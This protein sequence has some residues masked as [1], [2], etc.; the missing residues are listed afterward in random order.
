MLG[1]ALLMCSRFGRAVVRWR[2]ACASCVRRLIRQ[3]RPTAATVR[4]LPNPSASPR[5]RLLI[6]SLL[7]PAY[8]TFVAKPTPPPVP[9]FLESISQAIHLSAPALPLRAQVP[10]IRPRTT[11]E[12]KRYLL[13]GRRRAVRI[14][15][16][17]VR[18]ALLLAFR[19]QLLAIDRATR[20]GLAPG[21]ESESDKEALML[22][23]QREL[24]VEAFM[25]EDPAI[26]VDGEWVVASIEGFMDPVRVPLAEVKKASQQRGKGGYRRLAVTRVES[27]D[28]GPANGRSLGVLRGAEISSSP[29][30][31]SETMV[32]SLWIVRPQHCKLYLFRPHTSNATLTSMRAGNSKQILF[33]GTLMRWLE[34]VS[35][36]AARRVSVTPWS[37][38]AIDSLSFNSAVHPGEVVYIRAV[39]T[40]V[41]DSSVECY[42][43]AMAED[44]N[45][46]EP[47]MRLVSESFFSLVRRR[48]PAQ[49]A[50]ENT[51][52][53]RARQV[54]I[55]PVSGR[56]LKGRLRQV[57][58]PDGPAMRVAEGADKRR[59]DRLQD[60]RILQRY[61]SLMLDGLSLT[62]EL[63]CAEFMLEDSSSW[64]AASLLSGGLTL[65]PLFLLLRLAESAGLLTRLPNTIVHRF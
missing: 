40:K 25:K 18:D 57:R 26:S 58:V 55:D 19:A 3:F 30:D 24:V 62:L 15:G 43:L 41:W 49:Q 4:H 35:S 61:V 48:F 36:V 33:G 60:K 28:D 56:P 31:L 1:H 34:E 22:E 46:R 54:A 9:T 39:V 27:D 16:R 44:R 52:I 14:L 29:L 65:D 13:A 8:L 47:K 6:V 38:A 7:V 12:S 51:D 53:F 5:T 64:R 20:D 2:L 50:S 63:S 23:L 45:S 11:L 21:L 37:S 17:D 59:E 10:A 42:A 32:M